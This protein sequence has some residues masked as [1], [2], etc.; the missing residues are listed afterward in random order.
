MRELCIHVYSIV[1][2]LSSRLQREQSTPGLQLLW[3][4]VQ[5]RAGPCSQP[6]LAPLPAGPP[7][8]SWLL[9]LWPQLPPLWLWPGP[10]LP[11][12]PWL[13]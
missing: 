11:C 9:C 8:L 2:S 12:S 4:A 10:R 1:L 13:A 5:Q 6:Q 7:A 3:R